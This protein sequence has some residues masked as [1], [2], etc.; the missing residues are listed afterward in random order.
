MTA[1]RRGRGLAQATI[2]LRDACSEILET[3]QP[4]SVRAVCYQ[5][6]T[7][8]LLPDMSKN[9]TAKVSR[10]LTQARE[11]GEI[12]W[13]WIVDEHRSLERVSAWENPADFADT[14][15]DAYRR[16]R[17]QD[18]GIHV[19][20][21]S[22]KGTIR[23]TIQPVLDE[24]GVGLRVKGGIPAPHHPHDGEPEC[25]EDQSLLEAPTWV[26]LATSTVPAALL[27]TSRMPAWG[28]PSVS[29]FDMIMSPTRSMSQA[30]LK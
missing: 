20:V 9:S 16:D 28:L 15:R 2:A 14:I 5:L 24:Y 27:A 6:F 29:M 11:D 26:R 4:A 7:Q 19:E 18:Q 21:W 17:W 3:I 25:P 22:E 8:K 13:R 10:I 23:G 30:V 12:P 1:T